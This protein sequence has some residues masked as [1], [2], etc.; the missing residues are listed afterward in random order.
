MLFYN[1][2]LFS[3]RSLGLV[4]SIIVLTFCS[5]STLASPGSLRDQ[6]LQPPPVN[7]SPGSKYANTNR[8]WQG[9][10]GIERSKNGRLWVVWYSGGDIV[11]QFKNAEG[12]D[13][14]IVLVTSKDNGQSWSAPKLVIDPPGPVRAFDPVLWHD[15]LGRLWLFWSQSYDWFDGRVGLWC[16]V[17]E[18]SDSVN[19]TWSQPRRLCNGIMMNKPTVLQNGDWLLPV[20]LWRPEVTFRRIGYMHDGSDLDV[21]SNVYCSRDQGKTW[22]LRGGVK[23]PQSNCDENMV[24]QRRD[25]SLWM[26]I[27][28]Y[29]GI[30]ETFSKDGGLTWSSPQPSKIKHTVSRFFIRRLDSGN[31]ILVKHGKI[32]QKTKGRRDLRA[33]ISDDDGQTWRGGLMLDDR[34][35]VSY[36]DGVQAPDGRIYLTYDYNRHTDKEIYIAVFTEADILAGK[37]VNKNS[38]LRI[39]VN[40][41]GRKPDQAADNH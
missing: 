23:V 4:F 38:Q 2:S 36:P 37:I 39:L 10:P 8:H 28:T 17:T 16:I 18:N 21:R 12:P 5:R 20:A 40:K 32:D 14:Y 26:L 11:P 25:G 31:L 13:N 30:A 27:R 15:P 9:I 6:A 24:V 19:P 29:Y 1:N 22:S 35:A 3:R 33:F 34:L 41:A 7:C